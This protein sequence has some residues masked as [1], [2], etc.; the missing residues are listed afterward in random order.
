MYTPVPAKAICPVPPVP[1]ADSH[2]VIGHRIVVGHFD[3]VIDEAD[4]VALADA[5]LDHRAID[6]TRECGVEERFAV[7][8]LLG[9][10]CAFQARCLYAD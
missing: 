2:R 5:R 8:V 3:A 4:V 7:H 6:E 10:E 1:S 9:L